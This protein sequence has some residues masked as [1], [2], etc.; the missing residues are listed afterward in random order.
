MKNSFLLSIIISIVSFSQSYIDSEGVPRDSFYTVQGYY[1]KELK[2]FPFIK[3]AKVDSTLEVNCESNL[4]YKQIGNRKLK[5]DL[6]YPKDI[7]TKLPIV[8]FIHGGG[9]KSGDKS[10]QHPMAVEI[11]NEGY[12]CAAVEYRLSPEKKYPA[13]IYDIKSSIKWLKQNAEHYFAYSSRVVLAG[14]SSGGHLA[15]LC[16][17]TSD[18]FLIDPDD[19]LNYL[20]AKVSNVIDIDGVLDFTDPAESGK[21]TNLAK[22][23]VGKLWFGK[24]FSED[25]RKWREASPIN[26]INQTSPQFLFIN[27]SIERF[28]AGRD[29]ASKLFDQ[30]NIKY[31]IQTLKETPHTFWLFH[32]WFYQT[33]EIIIDYLKKNF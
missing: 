20:S 27:S 5:L 29:I 22:P 16:G 9:W 12:L 10:F 6:F 25:P 8:I 18:Y 15:A 21:D 7:K 30:Y 3:I 2:N 33:K 28:H 4:V 13:A 32:P 23:S 11:A 26:Y 31:A 19:S 14:C 17:V 24:S 1:Q